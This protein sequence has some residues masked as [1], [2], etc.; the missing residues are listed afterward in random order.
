MVSYRNAQ[1]GELA[2]QL[3]KYAPR[4]RKLQQLSR[5]REFAATLQPGQSYPYDFVCYRLTRFKPDDAP[6][7]VFDGRSLLADLMALH[8]ELSDTLDLAVEWAGEPVM[9]L[10]EVRRTYDVSLKTVR[11]WRARGLVAYRFVFADGRKLTG[12]RQSDL[13]DFVEANPDI[14]SRTGAYSY[15]DAGTR[16]AV[17]ARAFELSLTEELTF[18]EAVGRL[19]REF[20][21]SH[22]SLRGLLRRYDTEHPEAPIFAQ[23]AQPLSDAE[24]RQILALYRNGLDA[25][26]LSRAFL[27]GRSTVER[28][29]RELTVEDILDRDWYYVACDDFERPDAEQAILGEPLPDDLDGRSVAGPLTPDA[30]QAFFR[31]YNF[32]KSQLAQARD[33]LAPSDLV[34]A[35]VQRIVGL[36]HAAVAVRNCLVVANL[37]LVVHLASRH[38]ALG[39]P[40]DDL[41][42]DGTVSLMQAIE[43]FDYTRGVRF[44]TY[45]SWA[46]RKNFAKTIPHEIHVRH[47]AMTGA[48]EL[49]DETAGKPA[50]SPEGRELRGVLRSTVASLLLELGPREREVVVARFGLGREAETLEQIGKRF[51]ITRERVRQ[52]EAR[53]LRKLAA[54]VDPALIDDIV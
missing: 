8:H 38:V 10:D 13:E 48:Q 21:C 53:A 17:V 5:I 46:I 12:V 2:Q 30:E 15:I 52:I 27:L 32:L 7:A 37:R 49:I 43:R 6:H 4:A 14:I 47:A 54:L 42:S 9:S 24:R 20:G 39:R 3:L 1:V 28:V 25:D 11:R 18:T 51:D 26:E 33:E 44:S 50:V 23:A 41:V 19:A 45:A 35:A 40:L 29:V 16:R 22:G 36:H 34:P 31:R